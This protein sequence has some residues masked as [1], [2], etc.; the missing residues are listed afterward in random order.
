MLQSMWKCDGDA[1]CTDGSDEDPEMCAK[2]P[3]EIGRHRCSKNICV[4]REALCDGR[5]DCGDNSDEN[6]EVR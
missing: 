6:R 5:N 1:D 2:L 3:C 4:G